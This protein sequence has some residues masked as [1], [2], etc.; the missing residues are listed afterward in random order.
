MVFSETLNMSEPNPEFKN[1]SKNR[2]IKIKMMLSCI[3]V[4]IPGYSINCREKFP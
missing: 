4:S 1:V 2:V 3:L